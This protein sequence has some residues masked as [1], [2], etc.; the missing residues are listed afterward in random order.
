VPAQ[1][2][3]E[4]IKEF[5]KKIIRSEKRTASEFAN[6]MVSAVLHILM[7]IDWGYQFEKLAKGN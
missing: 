4:L 2:D 3:R 5:F 7:A 1:V 6:T